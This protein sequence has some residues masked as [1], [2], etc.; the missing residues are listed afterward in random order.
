MSTGNSGPDSDIDLYVYATQE[1]P[2]AV[3]AEIIHQRASR[4]EVDNRFWEP[5]DEWL[6]AASGIA[7]DLM[8][9][10]PAWIE[11]QLDRVLVQHEASVGYSTSFWHNVRYSVTLF[12]RSGWFG[13]LQE[14]ANQPYP[15]ELVRAIVAKNRPILRDG[16]SSWLNQLEKAVRRNDIVAA[17]QKLAML[18][19]SYFDVLFAVNRATHPG[20]K[21]IL[22]LAVRCEKTPSGMAEQVEA[23]IQATCSADRPRLLQAGELLVDGLDRLLLAEGLLG[24]TND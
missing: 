23:L 2:V 18:L 3:R 6:E 8:Y 12:D 20:E 13:R 15:E 17:N 21:R 22:E 4:S 16:I 19:A 11:E 7:V 9:R 10:H 24:N 14:Q 5:G 1:I